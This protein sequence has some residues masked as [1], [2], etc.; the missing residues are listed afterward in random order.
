LQYL[1]IG[2]CTQVTDAG[3]RSLA[4]LP[5]LRDLRLVGDKR[6]TAKGL[7]QLTA[8]KKLN[9]LRLRDT[10]ITAQ[11]LQ[12]IKNLTQKVP[13]IDTLVLEDKS[14]TSAAIKKW[15][16]DLPLAHLSIVA[17][18]NQ[19]ALR[20]VHLDRTLHFPDHTSLGV[21]YWL[22]PECKVRVDSK[23]SSKVGEAKGVVGVPKRANLLL[24]VGNFAANDPSLLTA[25]GPNFFA[26]L[27]FGAVDTDDKTLA[28]ISELTGLQAL[29]LR[30]S[31]LSDQ[32]L[33]G[34]SKLKKLE[35]LYLS[36]TSVSDQGLDWLLPLGS[37]KK[38]VLDQTKISNNGLKSIQKCRNLQ[39]LAMSNCHITDAGLAS[40]ATL[41]ELTSLELDSNK[42]ITAKG[43]MQLA[44]SKLIWLSI[45]DTSVTAKDLPVVEKL[46][47]KIP[48]LKFITVN[49]KSFTSAAVREWQFALPH[50]S[51]TVQQN[52]LMHEESGLFAPLHSWSDR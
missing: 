29:D 20:D 12:V 25:Y 47:E 11:D 17:S 42:G 33:K 43:L 34:L 18:A 35:E 48:S 46:S 31:D 52:L 26:A 8:L 9:R 37:L 3:L 50:I 16:H 24:K 1:G 19:Q 10:G 14:F 32:G 45:R 51:T 6:I 21:L 38:L 30:E 49:G 2:K 28:K 27:N 41:S 23:Q 22:P 15:K 40:L 44:G 4:S 7:L 13:S 36:R 39:D 5:Q